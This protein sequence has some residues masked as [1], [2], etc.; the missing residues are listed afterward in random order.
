[1]Q[2]VFQ[3]PYSSLNPRMTVGESVA[4]PLIVHRMGD[5]AERADRVAALFR[6]VG[7]DPVFARRY[8]HEFSGG[9]RQRLSI[10]RALASEPRFIVADEPITALDVSIQAQIINLF[11]DLQAQKELSYL[12]IAHDLAMVRY[13]CHR[14]AVM[15]QGRFVEVGPTAD[16]FRNAA[17]S[18]TRS[19]I[20]AMPSLA[21][22][23]RR[24][25]QAAPEGGHA[26]GTE[27][28]EVSAGHFVLV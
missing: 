9:Q 22:V 24:A 6:Q 27:Y 3:D 17:H 1:M 20:S 11:K 10:A 4:E 5:R 23:G 14:V 13:L 26:V 15:Y 2:A 12:F 25:A 7:L 19:L 8:P 28:Q 18:Y 21:L 16:V